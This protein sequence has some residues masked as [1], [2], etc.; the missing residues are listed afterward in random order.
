MPKRD[1]YEDI[2]ESG[3]W[4]VADLYSKFKIAKPLAQA[5]EYYNIALF[6]TSTLI[7]DLVENSGIVID[8]G[9]LDLLKFKGFERLISTLILVIDNSIFALDKAKFKTDKENLEEE[10]KHLLDLWKLKHLLYKKINNQVRKTQTFKLDGVKYYSALEKVRT[11]KAKINTPLNNAD[12]IFTNK[13]EFDPQ[14]Y[15][16]KIFEDATERG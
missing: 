3:N 15:K 12:L 16:K 2:S 5:D 11:I 1:D 4:N 9:Q 6:G 7:D 8:E 14:K 13:T 10:Q